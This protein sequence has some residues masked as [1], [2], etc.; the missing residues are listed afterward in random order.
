MRETS[1]VQEHLPWT[2]T[3]DGHASKGMYFEDGTVKRMMDSQVSE[4]RRAW[5]QSNGGNKMALKGRFHLC[6]HSGHYTA[7]H[8]RVEGKLTESP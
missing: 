3:S 6:Q 8:R 7:I 5:G 1:K 4:V 2:S